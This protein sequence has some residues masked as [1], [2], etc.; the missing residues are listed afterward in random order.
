MWLVCRAPAHAPIH[1]T[2]PTERDPELAVMRCKHGTRNLGQSPNRYSM[3]SKDK[4]TALVQKI[5]SQR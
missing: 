2:F 3:T 1:W 5:D 4:D